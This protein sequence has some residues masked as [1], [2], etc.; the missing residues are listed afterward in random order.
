MFQCPM[1][2]QVANLDASVSM[3]SL[4]G[5]DNGE[6]VE[7]SPATAVACGAHEDGEAEGWAGVQG[8]GEWGGVK[9]EGEEARVDVNGEDERA[10]LSIGNLAGSTGKKEESGSRRQSGVGGS[11]GAISQVI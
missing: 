7:V 10:D 5:D 2:R 9:A 3:E 6:A 11:G 8:E 4:L 1:C